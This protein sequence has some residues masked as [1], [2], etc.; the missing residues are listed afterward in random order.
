MNYSTGRILDFKRGVVVRA[1]AF[2]V[3]HVV[4]YRKDGSYFHADV[5]VKDY[6][7]QRT[8][9]TKISEKLLEYLTHFNKGRKN[10]FIW[11]SEGR[12]W[13]FMNPTDLIC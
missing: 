6:V 8:K 4:I 1:G 9:R 13:K 5:D 11:D 3:A 10:R 12:Q 7:L 2:L